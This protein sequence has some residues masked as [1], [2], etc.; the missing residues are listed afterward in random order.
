MKEI[1]REYAENKKS[2]RDMGKDGPVWRFSSKH[3]EQAYE[4][5]EPR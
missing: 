5:E 1:Y 3:S 4:E 2:G